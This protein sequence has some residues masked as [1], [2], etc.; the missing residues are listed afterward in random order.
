MA[1][2]QYQDWRSVFDAYQPPAT[3]APAEQSTTFILNSDDGQTRTVFTGTGFTCQAEV[4]QQ[5]G[6]EISP[7]SR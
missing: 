6:C 2:F 3:V 4:L 5:A 7:A 1:E